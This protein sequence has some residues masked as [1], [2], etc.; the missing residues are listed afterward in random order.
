MRMSKV[1]TVSECTET[2]LARGLCSRH[3]QKWREYGDP[4]GQPKQ[5]D[6]HCIKCGGEGPFEKGRRVCKKCRVALKSE[7][8]KASNRAYAKEKHKQIRAAVLTHYGY[9][10]LCC[11][12]TTEKFLSI[13][14][15]KGGG[16]IHRKSL[17][18]STRLY[19]WLI[20]EGFPEG[21][22]VLCHNCNFAKSHWPG[23][24]P[25]GNKGSV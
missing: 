16:C 13:D 8:Q 14:H 1:C 18:S 4:L 23:G 9:R 20:K 25:H 22:Q 12:E 17:G 6:R 15:V 19:S 10:C 3:Y 7:S 21:F 11:G 2:P 5:W 24:C